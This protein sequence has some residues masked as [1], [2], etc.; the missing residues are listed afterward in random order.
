[1]LAQTVFQSPDI[2]AKLFTQLRSQASLDKKLGKDLERGQETPK[3]DYT[4]I[5]ERTCLQ[6]LQTKLLSLTV[7]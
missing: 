3:L 4:K 1:M 7:P 5:D 6:G 2:P